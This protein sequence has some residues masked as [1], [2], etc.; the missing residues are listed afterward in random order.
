MRISQQNNFCRVRDFPGDFKG[1]TYQ[2]ANKFNV[3]QDSR[4]KIQILFLQTQI[5][6]V[7]VG[8]YSLKIHKSAYHLFL[9]FISKRGFSSLQTR[10]SFGEILSLNH[11]FLRP[12][13]RLVTPYN[14]AYLTSFTFLRNKS[15][16]FSYQIDCS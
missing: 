14:S 13:M 8:D 1:P 10:K 2:Y 5:Y 3:I 4:F 12:G 7:K 6:K 9:V 16:V 11:R 15:I